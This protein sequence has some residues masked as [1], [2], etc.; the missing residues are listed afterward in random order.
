MVTR[1]KVSRLQDFG[2]FGWAD[3]VRSEGA[4][5]VPLDEGHELVDRLLDMP[6]LPR[7][8]KLL[9]AETEDIKGSFM[10]F[11]PNAN[12]GKEPHLSVRGRTR[13]MKAALRVLSGNALPQLAGRAGRKGQG[14][15]L[16]R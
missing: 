3:L 16:L 7:I 1:Q 9:I 5:E 6:Q 13:C 14:T 15:Q 8:F 12:D 10:M 2:A 4:I 11:H